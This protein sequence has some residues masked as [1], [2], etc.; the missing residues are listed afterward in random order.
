MK[1]VT[2][3]AVVALIG[4]CGVL[5]LATGAQSQTNSLV[6]DFLIEGGRVDPEPDIAGLA[7]GDPIEGEILTTGQ[8][9]KSFQ[10][11]PAVQSPR[12]GVVDAGLLLSIES[13]DGTMSSREKVATCGR[14]ELYSEPSSPAVMKARCDAALFE[15][16]ATAEGISFLRNGEEIA[17][18][19]LSEGLYSINGALHRILRKN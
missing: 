11:R 15:Y 9:L 4:A 16:A 17:V 10:D 1:I 3:M 6:V 7:A 12:G 13:G 14:L 2:R 18:Y 5:P 8:I 19:E